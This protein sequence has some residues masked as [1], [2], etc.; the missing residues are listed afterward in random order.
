MTGMKSGAGDDPF[1]DVTDDD[2]T[3]TGDDSRN[4]DEMEPTER[5]T[6]TTERRNETTE[7]VNDRVKSD[8][9]AT[10]D[11]STEQPRS[12]GT[13]GGEATTDRSKG[14][15]SGQPQVSVDDLPYIA[16][17]NVRGESVKTGR[18]KNVLFEL[19][20]DIAQR[21]DEFVS[22]LERRLGTDVPKTDARE[23]ALAAIWDR[24]EDVV[25]ILEEW[26][27]GYFED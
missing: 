18:D 14:D 27:L 25:P 3:D 12:S 10:P 7:R 5:R 1:A 22:E 2:D 4:A 11:R 9:S 17:R 23:A 8:R 26:G 20:P 16:R 13:G 6:E 15:A 21:E 19:R 24:P